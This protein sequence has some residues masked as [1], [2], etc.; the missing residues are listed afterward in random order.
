MVYLV[1]ILLIFNSISS[2]QSQTPEWVLEHYSTNHG[3]TSP[4]VRCIL[5]DK[6]GYLWFGTGNGLANF[7]PTTSHFIHYWQDSNYREGFYNGWTQNEYCTA[8][9][10]E[11]LNSILWIGTLGGLLELNADR[12]EF[13]LY[14][15]DPEN[16]ESS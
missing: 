15:Y 10:Q 3:L 1:L 2:I 9:L 7:D 13:T 16:S 4:I 14:E 11:D 12:H 6:T 5:Q 8:A